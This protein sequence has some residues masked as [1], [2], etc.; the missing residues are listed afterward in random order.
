MTV[1]EGNRA[2]LEAFHADVIRNFT[3]DILSKVRVIGYEGR[4]FLAQTDERFDVIDLRL[5]D[6]VGLS[7]PGGF[8]IVEKFSYTKEAMADLYARARSGRR[9]VGHAVEQGGAAE[10][11]IEALRD[12]GRGG[13]RG[14]PR[15]SGQL[16]LRRLIVPFDG[17]RA[18]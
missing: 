15:A 16:L 9:A 12:D 3:G 1:A 14:R 5:A 8:A 11:G 4:H 6:S 13:A 18:L 2:V 7:N 10:V 17:D